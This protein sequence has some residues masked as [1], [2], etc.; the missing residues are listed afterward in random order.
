MNTTPPL[1]KDP[2]YPRYHLAPPVGWMN[3]PHPIFF[4]GAYHMFYQY[5]FLPNDPYGG[6]HCWGHAMSRD[7]VHWQHMPPGITPKDHGIAADRHIWSGCLVDNQGVGTAIYT[8]ENID[9]WM[10]TSADADLRTFTKHPANPIIK[11]PP[12]EPDILTEMRDPCVWKQGGFWYLV[13]GSGLK[14]NKGSLLPLYKSTD[15]VHWRYLHPLFRGDPAGGDHTFC[16][17]PSFFPLGDK[18]VLTLSHNAAWMTGTFKDEQFEPTQRGRLNYGRFY[19]PQAILDDKGRRILWGWAT[20]AR[21]AEA[22]KLAGW[23]SMQT[24][25]RVLSLAKDGTLR[26]DPAAELETLRGARHQQTLAPIG[27]SPV[28]VGHSEGMQLEMRATFSPGPGSRF[29]L[30]LRNENE[31]LRFEYDTATQ[32]LHRKAPR[33]VPAGWDVQ[34]T[35]TVGANKDDLAIPL[36]LSPGEPLTLRV[37][38]DRSVVEVFANRRVCLTERLYPADVGAVRAEVFCQA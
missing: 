15:L 7:L 37:F 22:L 16:E 33:D 24:L 6:P 29:G 10:S 12:A 21:D 18:H 5:S 17:C 14:D 20:E 8:I 11:G 28:P 30:I 26:F 3:D 27:N 4:K 32:T 35:D 13:V 31:L 9:I 1:L 34:N 19:V 36:E 38:L 23:A 2:H 25:P